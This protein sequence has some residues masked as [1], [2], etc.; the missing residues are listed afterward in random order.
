MINQFLCRHRVKKYVLLTFL[1]LA[2]VSCGTSTKSANTGLYSVSYW[3]KRLFEK[4]QPALVRQE[5][6][7]EFRLNHIQ[8]LNNLP[9][10]HASSL[11]HRTQP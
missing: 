10:S 7:L 11:R 1:V 3:A 6:F 2:L 9:G 8:S 5:S 4:S